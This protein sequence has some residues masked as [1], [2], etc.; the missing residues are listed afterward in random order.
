MSSSKYLIC[1]SDPHIYAISE[2]PF[3]ILNSK[4]LNLYQCLSNYY[5]NTVCSAGEPLKQIQIYVTVPSD[6][7][8]VRDLFE[9]ITGLRKIIISVFFG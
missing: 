2:I 3:D 8:I 9:L 7:G 4:A 1:H 5:I 6:R